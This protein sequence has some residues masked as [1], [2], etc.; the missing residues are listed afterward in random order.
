MTGKKLFFASLAALAFV[1]CSSTPDKS[2]DTETKSEN[3][4]PIIS[5]FET[6]TNAFKDKEGCFLLYDVTNKEYVEQFNPERCQLATAPCSTFKVP[7][8]VMGFDSGVLKDENTKF[9]WNHKKHEISEW[10]QDQTA[11][12]WMK[13][14]VL[15]YSQ[16]ITKRLGR[17]KVQ[18]YLDSM[19]YGNHDFSGNIES[20]WLTNGKVPNH[21]RNS[22]QINAYQQVDFLKKLFASTL[23]Q[24]Q[25]AQE[26]TRKIMYLEKTPDGWDFSGKTGSGYTGA[27]L[28]RRLGWFVAHLK[29]GTQEYVA[30]VTFNDKT[31]NEDLFGGKES[32]AIMIEALKARGMY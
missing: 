1:N 5:S 22:V 25:N 18:N 3:A 19:N 17:A 23:P 4:K 11:A 24:S 2:S 15:W 7:L 26:L 16:V 9:K 20:A 14:S 27:K 31:S 32:K 8:A 29:K 21:K 28:D 30:V 13:Y 6:L 12:T 10:N